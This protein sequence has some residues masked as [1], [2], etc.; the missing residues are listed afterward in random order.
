M[1]PTDDLPQNAPWWAHVIV[2]NWRSIHREISTWMLGV[3]GILPLLEQVPNIDKIFS[4]STW[5]DIQIAVAV[6]GIVAKYVS[7]PSLKETA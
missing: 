1:P 6:I 2:D 7:Q 4:A 3:A 5:E